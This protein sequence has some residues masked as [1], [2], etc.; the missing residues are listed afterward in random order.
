MAHACLSADGL[1]LYFASDMP[2]GFGGSD[3]YA[4]HREKRGRWGKPYN[5]GAGVITAGDEFFPFYDETARRLFFASDTYPGIGGLDVFVAELSDSG[6]SAPKNLGAP[7]NTLFDDFGFVLDASGE[8]GYFSS[9]REGNDDLY[10]FSIQAPIVF[11]KQLRG[12]VQ[13][14]N[15]VP[16]ADATV[17][18]LN[19]L[20]EQLAEVHTDQAGKYRCELAADTKELKLSISKPGFLPAET[21][22]K[23]DYQDEQI[24]A[25]VKLER[26]PCDFLYNAESPV[27]MV[28]F[29]FNARATADTHRLDSISECLRTNPNIKMELSGYTDPKGSKVYNQRLSRGRV[30]FVKNYLL[31]K[32]VK[33]EQIDRTQPMGEQNLLVPE[34]QGENYKQKYRRNRRVEINIKGATQ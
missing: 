19:A 7:I 21:L 24:R 22:L 31:S 5:L 10:S 3:L 15:G 12:V 27:F 28:Y 20:G 9:N 11:S 23:L 13:N 33:P 17:L 4:V 30:D 1:T 26:D 8:G 16:L 29:D 32:G 2:G 34:Q 25:D 14:K 18:I 6:F